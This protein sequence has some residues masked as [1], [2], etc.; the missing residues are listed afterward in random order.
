[1]TGETNLPRL[2]ATMQ[3]VLNPGEYVFCTT[4]AEVSVPAEAVLGSFREPEGLTLI[5]ARETADAHRLPYGALMAWL[6]LTLHSALEAVGLTAAVAAALTRANISCNV[7]AA[8]YHDHLFVAQADAERA[9]QVLRA[10]S[11]QATTPNP[12]AL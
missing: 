11:A 1:M 4:N 2:L 3:P 12:S 7:V 6:T 10:L 5:M 8:Y 9:L